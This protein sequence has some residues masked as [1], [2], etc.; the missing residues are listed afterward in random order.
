MTAG[1]AVP[2]G[3]DHARQ[4]TLT[5]AHNYPENNKLWRIMDILTGISPR[6]R[7][8]FNRVMKR[9]TEHIRREGAYRAA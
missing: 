2:C 9:S 6:F 5:E 1:T 7:D 3:I 8:R 4:K